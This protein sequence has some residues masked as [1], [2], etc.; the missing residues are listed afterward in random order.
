ME[1]KDWLNLGTNVVAI[2]VALLGA[3]W[4]ATRQNRK[5]LVQN[6]EMETYKEMWKAIERINNALVNFS[7]TVNLQL[8]FLE[9]KIN[10][11]PNFQESQPDFDYRRRTAISD[12]SKDYDKKVASITLAGLEFHQLWEQKEP[13]MSGL[14]IAFRTYQNEFDLLRDRVQFPSKTRLHLD[15]LN[16]QEM[17]PILEQENEKTIEACMRQLVYG[18]DLARLIQEDLVAGYFNYKSIPRSKKAEQ[19]YE[20]TREG[21][22]PIKK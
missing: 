9:N 21:L 5:I 20:L 14:N 4:F 18:M 16:F 13:L 12:Y 10:S 22:K 6:L 8:D 15:L 7:A 11:A 3:T 1:A 19:G 17:K 2:L